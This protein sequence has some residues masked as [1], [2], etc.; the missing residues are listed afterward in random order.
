MMCGK[1]NCGP[2]SFYADHLNW[3][4][5][6][7]EQFEAYPHGGDMVGMEELIIVD[8]GSLDGL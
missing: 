5:L 3:G 8:K 4:N 7:R 2:C 6:N 1:S